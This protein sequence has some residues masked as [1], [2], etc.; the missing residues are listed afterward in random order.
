MCG[1]PGKSL[2][3]CGKCFL[4]EDGEEDED[5]ES[6]FKPD[7]SASGSGGEEESDSDEDYSDEDE[8]SDDYEDESL[9]SEEESGKDWDE[10]EEEARRGCL[11]L[12]FCAYFQTTAWVLVFF[13]TVDSFRYLLEVQQAEH[14]VPFIPYLASICCWDLTHK[15]RQTDL[16]PDVTTICAI[17]V[18]QSAPH[19]AN[20]P[21]RTWPH[22]PH[23]PFNQH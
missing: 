19:V 15:K 17:A 22:S 4:Q 23:R 21:P 18:L 14:Q 9:G 20:P 2:F 8:E 1:K 6:D 5:S 10:L 3:G 12:C 13:E 11:F 7:E 16:C